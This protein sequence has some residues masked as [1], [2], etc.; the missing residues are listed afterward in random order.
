[1][2]FF[3]ASY[4]REALGRL[5][6]RAKLPGLAGL[7]KGMEDALGIRFDA[8]DGERLFRSTL[9]QTLFYGL[10]SAW[11]VHARA[12]KQN[13]DWRVS[14][15]S[16]HVPV[17]RLLFG[18]IATPQALQPLGL[19]PLLDAAG[20]AMERIERDPFFTAFSD[21]HAVQYFYE[22]F[23]QY[24]D[25]ELRRQLGVWYTPS[26][27]VHFQV[28]RVDRILRSELGVKSGLADQNVWVLDPCCGTGSYIVA[29]LDRIRKTLNGQ[30]LGD[31]V[32]EE[33][34]KAATTRIVGFE[35]MTAPFV[36]SHWQVGERLHDA[37]LG[38]NERAAVYL[39]NVLTGWKPTDAGPPI[40]GY[41]ELVEERGA[42]AAVKRDRPILVVLGNP[43]YNAYAGVS[44][45]AE[46]GLVEP[47]KVGLIDKWGVR[48]FNLDDLYVRF[49][50]I[51]ARRIAEGTGRGI[52]SYISNSSWISL[53]SFTVMRESLLQNFDRIWIENMHGDRTITEYGPD[54]RSSE[55]VFAIDGFSPGIWQGVATSLLVRSGQNKAPI[56]RYRN[57]LNASDAAQRR[58]DLV[59]SLDD[60]NASTKYERLTPL[61]ANRYVLRPVT[62]AHA[63]YGEWPTIDSLLRVAPLPGLLEKRGGGLIDFD[64]KKL[65][66][67]IKAY[68]DKSSTFEEARDA[69]QALA[70]NRAGYDAKK[71]RF[72]FVTEG[73]QPG[74]VQRY[75]YFA[76]DL[77]Y[78]Y[79]TEQATV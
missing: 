8:R 66:A 65:K 31:L 38:A 74:N 73:F 11:V 57:D 51:A 67:R 47:Y 77:R 71:V 32:A 61:P 18:Q 28:E 60:P 59:A 5:S 10:F 30:G 69:N 22:P 26:E 7:R 49:F 21:T 52:V 2:A 56:Y 62:S 23:L 9:V 40:P 39:T 15:W 29:V 50:R 64:R 14:Q 43:P 76:F 33:L 44:P 35:I 42:A 54:G 45:D 3:L 79:T 13:F 46:G 37:P 27:I 72:R 58:A 6:E 41:E 25:P 48:K 1:M 17:M 75:A 24:Y 4:A 36:I 16:L 63:S 70:T 34:K 20:A 12:G 78:A 68:L 53:P 19:V 55:T